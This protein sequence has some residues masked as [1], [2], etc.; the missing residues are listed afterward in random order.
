MKNRTGIIVLF[1]ACV[2]LIVILIWN[3][4]QTSKQRRADMEQIGYFSNRY[5][6]ATSDL[7]EQRQVNV[8]LTNDISTMS[9]DLTGL[10]NQI[11]DLTS[12]LSK[13][14]D[15]LKVSQGEVTKRDSKISDLEQQNQALEEKAQE[16]SQSI[17]NLT[18]KIDDTQKKLAAAEGD[19]AFLEKEL[20][21]MMAE[22]AELERQFNDLAVLR[23]QVAKIKEEVAIARRLEWMRNGVLS[24]SEQKGGELLMQK[25]PPGTTSAQAKAPKT[26]ANTY[27]LNVEVSADGTVHVIPPMT[28]GAATAPAAS[29]NAA[30]Q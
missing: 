2:V 14:E 11:A 13:T 10:S 5:T 26:P 7:D 9:H 25:N 12:N 24:R 17:T 16:L 22:K 29:T 19:K 27:D 6:K 1:L 18:A 20:Q 4:N 30:G 8:V 23:A 28:N 3:Q 21:R 15:S